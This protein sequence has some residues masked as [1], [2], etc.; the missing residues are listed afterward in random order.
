MD[1]EGSSIRVFLIT[2]LLLRPY[3]L[4]LLILAVVL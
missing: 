3:V 4:Q 2:G 1:K